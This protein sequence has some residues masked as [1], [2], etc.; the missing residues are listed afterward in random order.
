MS[1]AAMILVNNPGSWASVYPPFRHADWNGWTFADLVFPFFLYITGASLVLSL[2]RRTA[3]G[4]SGSL[5][6]WHVLWRSVALLAIG[7]LL[8]GLFFLPFQH[9]R[10]PGVLQRIALVYS[11]AALVVMTTRR[12]TWAITSAMVLLGYW[13]LMSLIPV[14]GYGNGNLA[15]LGNAASYVDRQLLAG[16]LW[17]P[18]WDPEGI[19][20]TLPAVTTVLFGALAAN[21][22]RKFPN[23]RA[24]TVA[25]KETGM[26]GM[27][28][29]PG[30][31][32]AGLAA[33]ALGEL[34]ARVFPINKNLWTSSFALFT[35]GLA[36]LVLAGC[37]WLIEIKNWRRLGQ[38]FLPL[39][40]NPLAIYVASEI[41]AIG[42]LSQIQDR[43][44]DRWFAHLGS[45]A[46][47]SLLW[48]VAYL[49]VWMAVAKFLY[50]K[51]IFVR[52]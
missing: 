30:L 25:G 32:M 34:W 47:G 14:P 26:A 50:R 17:Q 2:D 24:R 33:V 21:W 16:H 52:L 37:Y 3:Q 51:A 42:A 31:L 13:A 5:L 6:L 18:A 48:A 1:I 10:L 15:P 38:I 11:L 40:M 23:G 45:A 35:A 39:G 49:L 12:R 43:L 4:A 27:G 36:T 41:V 22:L 20:S 29:I 19:L 8:N 7:L 9:V 44:Y 28:P 46:L